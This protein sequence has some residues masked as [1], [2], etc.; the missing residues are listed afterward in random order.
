MWI[1]DILDMGNKETRFSISK[2]NQRDSLVFVSLIT[3]FH[4]DPKPR[5]TICFLDTLDFDERPPLIVTLV[6]AQHH[7]HL[8]PIVFMD[9]P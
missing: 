6:D 8:L 9:N 3:I 2:P 7:A 4:L 1:E 5:C